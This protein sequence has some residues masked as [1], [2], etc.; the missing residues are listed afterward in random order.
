MLANPFSGLFLPY[1][2]EIRSESTLPLSGSCSGMCGMAGYIKLQLSA[3]PWSTATCKNASHFLLVPFFSAQTSAAL[4]TKTLKTDLEGKGGCG[5]WWRTRI[6]GGTQESTVTD[7]AA[8]NRN[9]CSRARHLPNSPFLA[10]LLGYL[11]WFTDLCIEGKEI[12]EFF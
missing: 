7:G 11:D 9:A 8:V 3:Q 4:H 2:S 12:S 10:F 6:G 5:Q 1:L